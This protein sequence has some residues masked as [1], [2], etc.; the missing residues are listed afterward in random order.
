MSEKN[1]KKKAL[2]ALTKKMAE[3]AKKKARNALTKELAEEARAQGAKRAAEIAA[4]RVAEE[5]AEERKKTNATQPAPTPG[6]IASVDDAIIACFMK[7]IIKHPTEDQIVHAIKAFNQLKNKPNEQPP[8][9]NWRS[10]HIFK[11]HPNWLLAKSL[12]HP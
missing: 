8:M 7:K 12:I 6:P 5:M 2:N 9:E 11:D 10:S 1:A 3:D 4:K